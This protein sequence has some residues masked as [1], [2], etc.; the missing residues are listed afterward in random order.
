MKF[1]STELEGVYTIEIEKFEDERGFFARAWCAKEFEAAGMNP[2]LV[3]GNISYCGHR[4][5]LRGM[6]YQ[7]APYEEAKCVRCTRG[8]IYDVCIDLRPESPSFLKWTGVELSAQNHRLIYIP[9]G[10]A[11][12]YVTLVDNTEIFYLVS[13]YYAPEYERGV[14]W[15]D[16]R[17]SI[18]WPITDVIISEKD[19]TWPDFKE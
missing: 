16:K 6:H 9:E 4:G 14:R 7:A 10:F 8:A 3:Q 12:G 11:H 17:F 15:D 2:N 18:D 19:K 1:V 5:T 13:Q